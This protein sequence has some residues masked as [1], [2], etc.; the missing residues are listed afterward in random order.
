MMRNVSGKYYNNKSDEFKEK[1]LSLN[2]IK[3]FFIS[4]PMV[5]LQNLAIINNLKKVKKFFLTLLIIF[6]PV[7]L[8]A[9]LSANIKVN[10]ISTNS[11]SICVGDNAF[12]NGTPTG[13]MIPYTHSW[14]GDGGQALPTNANPTDFR[15]TTPG[16]Y[17]VVYVVTDEASATATDTIIVTVNPLPDINLT[18]N[19]E[20]YIC[21]GNCVDLTAQT[22]TGNIILLYE[23]NVGGTIL[24]QVIG[25]PP[26]PLT[27]HVCPLI[28]TDYL[29]LCVNTAAS[30]VRIKKLTIN[31]INFTVTAS[32][33]PS[34]FCLG[35]TSQL[36]AT[37]SGGMTPYIYSWSPTATLTNPI[38]ANP[39]ATPLVTT[40]YTVTVTE[41]SPASCQQIVNV[42]IIINYVDADAGSAQNICDGNCATLGGT[43][44][45][46]GGTAPYSY[47]WSPIATLNIPTLPN[48]SAC[49]AVTTTY[50]VTVTDGNGCTDTD[51][52]VITVN[53][54]PVAE[55]GV[56]NIIC[57][58][59]C[60]TIGGSP[61]ASGGTAPYTYNWNPIVGL[62][63]ST[64]P[65][66]QACPATTTKYFVTVTDFKGCT[67]VDSVTVTVNPLPIA[68]AG[69][70]T[71]IC[72][73][74][75]IIIGGS[76]TASGGTPPY[77]YDWSPIATLDIPTNSNP[78][79]C[80]LVTTTYFVTVTDSKGCT[81]VDNVVITINPTIIVEAGMNDTLCNG[82][83]IIIG[84]SPTASGGTSP[85]SYNWSPATGL[86]F[87][88]IPN[89]QA[90]PTETTKY[91]VTVTD[92]TNCT[93]IDSITIKVNPS[94]IA[95]AGTNISMCNGSCVT[96]G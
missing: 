21:L 52:I 23:K 5:S 89:P 50:Y 67:A 47:S 96:I 65:N 54:K 76:P 80:P 20:N 12:L 72:L 17:T 86:N 9:Q 69:Q 64:L 60:V 35:G 36:L 56:G 68:E 92:N 29:A 6:S 90:C 83:C 78:E 51:N 11:L 41:S 14:T 18:S 77:T 37:P 74:S 27:A 10:G 63:N 79:A 1:N 88:N 46:V 38:I 22:T 7:I 94:P 31:V 49:P 71:T 75:C 28:T 84:G 30:C 3:T 73:G 19:P 8:F 13:G 95:E 62:D 59:N 16:V 45:A 61:T 24:G 40:T 85:Y 15:A 91:F 81:D 43:P 57:N 26:T 93:N 70:N 53:P 44:T 25:S 82:G 33:T 39:I 42:P 58:T 55:A 34:T 48:P 32:A 2:I 66:P 87:S 4:N